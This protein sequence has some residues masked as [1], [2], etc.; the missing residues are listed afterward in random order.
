VR[1]GSGRAL[2]VSRELGDSR[3]KRVELTIHKQA[4]VSQASW[5]LTSRAHEPPLSLIERTGY[6]SLVNRASFNSNKQA[7]TMSSLNSVEQASS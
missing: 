4:R 2:N 3:V 7:S 6:V 5:S 1:V